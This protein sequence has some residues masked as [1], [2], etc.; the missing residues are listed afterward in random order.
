[1]PFAKITGQGLAAI[2]VAV[3]LLWTCVLRERALTRHAFDERV[4]V[5]RE[6]E[7]MQRRPNPVPVWMRHDGA[8]HRPARIDTV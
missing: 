6:I 7:L 8:N 2:A 4:R 3:A 5:M 1:M